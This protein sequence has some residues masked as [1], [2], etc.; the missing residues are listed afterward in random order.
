MKHTLAVIVTLTFGFFFSLLP[1]VTQF[2]AEGAG[3]YKGKTIKI[4]EGRRPGG[5]GS[6]RTTTTVKH[7]KKYLGFS[8]AVFQY[9]P[10]AG[11]RGAVN[12][13]V[14]S[15]RRDGL[16]IG[17]SSSGIFA[18]AILGTRGVR[19]KLEEL[20]ILG[21]GSPG[22]AT[23]LSVRPGLKLDSVEKLKAYK[24]LR[25]ANRSVG[26]SMYMR[27]R[28]TAFILELKNPRWVLGYS[29]AE[30]RLALER[31]EADGAFGGIA[32][33]L[34][35]SP[36]WIEEG[37]SFPIVLPDVKGQGA[38]AY[39]KFPQGIPTV[40]QYANT[41]LK[42]DLIRLHHSTTPGGSLFYVYKGIPKAAV[43][44]LKTAFDKVW[45]DPEFHKDYHRIT[46]QKADPMTGEDYTKLL[47]NRP[48]N[49]ELIKL[50]K[51][52]G[53]AGPLPSSQ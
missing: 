34:R 17:N 14:K 42:K 6:L 20:V 30:I 5:T 22:G 35:D 19:Y 1:I 45:R 27:D 53:S 46:R 10:G 33:L 11:G 13:V 36:H 9:I 7:L 15:A 16:T 37:F 21:A 38:E 49:P 40:D 44:E 31:G 2:E 48:R 39:P 24:G 47:R 18:A 3:Y 51:Q 29:S 26:H 8:A 32:G 4:V 41:K 43:K 28:L 50:Y 23:T 25:F 52:L 12:H